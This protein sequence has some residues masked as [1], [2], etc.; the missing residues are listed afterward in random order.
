M[1][2]SNPS[3]EKSDMKILNPSVVKCAILISNPFIG[4]MCDLDLINLSAGTCE[5]LNSNI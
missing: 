1:R 2:I 3:L 5:I 4:K